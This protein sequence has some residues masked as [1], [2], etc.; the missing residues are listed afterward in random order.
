MTRPPT[1]LPVGAD[2]T[3]RLT[4][5]PPIQMPCRWK[6]DPSVRLDRTTNIAA[7]EEFPLD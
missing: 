6:R 7:G 2:S 5:K 4:I 1:G 3:I